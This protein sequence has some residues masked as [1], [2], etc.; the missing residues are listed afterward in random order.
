[1]IES[2]LILQVKYRDG[3]VQRNSPLKYAMEGDC[4]LDLAYAPELVRKPAGHQVYED[5]NILPGTFK[6]VPTGV[7]VK[8]PEGN[9]GLLCGR[10]STFGK[11][12]LFVVESRI[13]SGYV[14]ELFL[15]VWHPNVFGGDFQIPPS[16]A[17]IKP[18]E[19]IGQI[20]II[21]YERTSI[22]VVD[23]LPDT[24]RGISGFGSTG[25]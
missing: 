8:I 24:Q 14:G 25:R 3:D 15:K 5:L 20:V 22:Q 1:M 9:F 10:S 16:A 18:W 21:P 4:G 13:D 11:R 2:H 12:G 17:V 19:R 23:E 7:S 6:I